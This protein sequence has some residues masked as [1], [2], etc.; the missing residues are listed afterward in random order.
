MHSKSNA[1]AKASAVQQAKKPFEV[2]VPA[3]PLGVVFVS[4]DDGA[5]EVDLLMPRSP[6]QFDGVERGATV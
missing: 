2:T 3:G 1:T 5:H 4:T 6:L